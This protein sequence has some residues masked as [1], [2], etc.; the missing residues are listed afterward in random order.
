ML[1]QNRAI[2]DGAL[3]IARETHADAI[4]LAAVLPGERQ[5][6]V[7]HAGSIR[8]VPVSAAA[9]TG[10]DGPRDDREI[11]SLPQ[12]RLRRRG[13][14]KVALLEALASGALNPGES[15]VVISGN[16]ISGATHLD[17][18]ALVQLSEADSELDGEP[19]APLA[20]LREVADPAIFDAVLMLCVELGHDGREGKPVGIT[21]TL[22]DHEHVLQRSHPL[23][24]NPFQG[25]V[26]EERNILVPSARRA[27]V[28][29]SGMDGAFVVTKEGILIAGGR[30]LQ[31]V[32]P[33]TRVPAGLGARHRAAAGITAATNAVSFCVSETSGDTRVFGGGRLLMTIARAD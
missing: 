1:N 16:D 10:V 14:A 6:L 11:L 17:T 8:V 3:T 31:D 23:V 21:V 32:G 5:Y 2:I 28:E 29:F 26:E 22:G 4:M 7:A 27:V 13:R 33:E 15:V 30:Y 18:V 12:V 9:G 24:M 19:G 25:H 20:I